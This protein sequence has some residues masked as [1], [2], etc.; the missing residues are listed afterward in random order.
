[1]DHGTFCRFAADF[2]IM[3]LSARDKARVLTR[4]Q[5]ITI[6]KKHSSYNKDMSQ[7]QFIESLDSVA[8]LY[9]NEKW[10]EL[11]EGTSVSDRTIEQKRMMLYQHL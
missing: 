1:M 6:F 7:G 9:Y 5:L 10:E 2:K 3:R 4:N 8:D 11:N